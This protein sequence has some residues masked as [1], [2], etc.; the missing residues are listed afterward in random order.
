M[1][2]F[3]LLPC[4]SSISALCKRL[5]IPSPYLPTQISKA[6]IEFMF[7]AGLLL[8]TGVII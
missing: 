4:V 2:F 3:A 8:F 6:D 5:E 1:P 7:L